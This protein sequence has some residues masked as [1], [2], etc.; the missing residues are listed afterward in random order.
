V[1]FACRNDVDAHTV[2][3]TV[4]DG[5]DSASLDYTVYLVLREDGQ[6]VRCVY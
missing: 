6:K 5:I 1:E 2:A 3:I 4:D